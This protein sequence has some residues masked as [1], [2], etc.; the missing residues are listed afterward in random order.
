MHFFGILNAYFVAFYSL[1][2]AH[3]CGLLCSLSIRVLPCDL[4]YFFSFF[5]FFIHCFVFT[6]ASGI[7]GCGGY[8][9]LL[10]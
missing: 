6:E 5:F 10:V 7:Y 4:S 3:T 8:L 2:D 1:F 9:L